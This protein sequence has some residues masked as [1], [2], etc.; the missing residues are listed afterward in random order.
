M[1]YKKYVKKITETLEQYKKEVDTL[2]AGLLL[3]KQKLDAKTKE[4]EGKWTE[5]YIQKYRINNNP[6]INCKARFQGLRAW[7]EPIILHYLEEIKKSLDQY[8]NAPVKVDFAN[9]ITTIKLSGLQLTD[10]EF[11]ILQEGATS[12]M[13]R[14]LLNQLAESRTKEASVA[15]AKDNG[16]IEYEK[17]IVKDPYIHLDL[18]NIEEI[19]EAFNNYKR[20]V[21]GL[22]YSYAGQNAKMAHLL[23]NKTPDYVAINMDVYFRKDEAGKFS[24]IMDQA[25]SILPENKIKRELT[26]ND[27]RLIDILINP[28]YPTLARDK[29]IKIAQCNEDIGELLRLDERYKDYLQDEES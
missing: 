22:L 24:T 27:K 14:R 2:E 7:A 8:F 25:N 9:K 6:D 4:M 21:T 11:S 23:D 18:P 15:K 1:R 13:E 20:A 3:G 17:G 26:E 12:Y 19:Y 10:L 5:E 16:Q 29:V 28:Q